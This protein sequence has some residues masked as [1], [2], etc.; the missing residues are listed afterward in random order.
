MAK[1][2][3]LDNADDVKS[4]IANMKGANSYRDVFVKTYNYYVK[5][6]NLVWERPKFRS[7]RRL[8]RIPT[9]EALMNVVSASSKKYAV[10]SRY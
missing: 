4:Y 5:L 1:H 10:I 9:R 2:C 6:N 3:D 7:E 8:P